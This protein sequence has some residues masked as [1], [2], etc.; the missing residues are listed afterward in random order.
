MMIFTHYFVFSAIVFMCTLSA[1]FADDW[2][3]AMHC[4]GSE[5]DL[6]L[7]HKNQLGNQDIVWNRKKIDNTGILCSNDGIICIKDVVVA[8]ECIGTLFTF[9]V[10][11]GGVWSQDNKVFVQGV[12]T[13][14]HP[15][16]ISRRYSFDPLFG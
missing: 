12:P 5:V 14:G 13:S 6:R 16:Y 2:T 7:G 15:D 10:Q 4:G 11:Y 1:V 9:K 8:G 3:V